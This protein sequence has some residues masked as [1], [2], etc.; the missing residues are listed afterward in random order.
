VVVAADKVVM[1]AGVSV[2]A[3]S[4]KSNLKSPPPVPLPES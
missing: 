1:D 2:L 3:P 4:V